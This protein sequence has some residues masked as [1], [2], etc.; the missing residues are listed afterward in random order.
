MSEILELQAE[1]KEA[2]LSIYEG[3][4][5]FHVISDTKYQYRVKSLKKKSG[6][7]QMNF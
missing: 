3:D 2:L 1:E 4:D 6:P 5:N 7:K